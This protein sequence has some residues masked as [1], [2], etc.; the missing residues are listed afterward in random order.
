MQKVD[1]F[2]FIDFQRICQLTSVSFNQA[3]VCL[4]YLI[5]NKL[6]LLNQSIIFITCKQIVSFAFQ[7]LK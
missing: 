7:R 5:L 3:D 2:T 4:G 1:I 6:Q